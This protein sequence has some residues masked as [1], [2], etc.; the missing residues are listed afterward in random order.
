M[1]GQCF[2]RQKPDDDKLNGGEHA[3]HT[4][5]HWD[6]SQVAYRA[7][8]FGARCI[9]VPQRGSYRYEQDCAKRNRQTYDTQQADS[10]NAFGQVNHRVR[11]LYS[12]K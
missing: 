3:Q 11:A 4:W 10:V 8:G 7:A 9:D 1:R 5:K 2:G 12:A 6:V